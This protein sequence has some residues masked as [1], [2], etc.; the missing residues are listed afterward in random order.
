MGIF[1]K[2]VF[3]GV[4]FK[5]DV[6]ECL[7][8]KTYSR[9]SRDKKRDLRMQSLTSVGADAGWACDVVNLRPRMIPMRSFEDIPVDLSINLD[10]GSPKIHPKKRSQSQTILTP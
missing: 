4:K 9:R 2:L 7:K 3:G 8:F 10:S 5:S 6:F 1:V